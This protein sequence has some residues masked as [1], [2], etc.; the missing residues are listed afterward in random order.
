VVGKVL[1][2]HRFIVYSM[3]GS[4]ARWLR[5]MGYDTVYAKNWHDA[6]IIETA[7]KEGR[8]IVTRDHGLYV[9]AVKRGLTAI[10]VPEVLEDA[11]ALLA[12]R[13]GIPLEVDP[14]RS[15]CPLCN[16]PLRKASPEEVRGKVPPRVLE[17]YSEFWVCTGCGQVYWRG[18]HWRG[19]EK[20][21]SEARK[22]LA[23][24]QGH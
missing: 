21:L 17:R 10:L 3:L 23:E 14:D 19:I 22:R 11:L 18:G 8:I 20:T 12:L 5:M 24:L 9:R 16:A 13:F 7:E 4:L 6:R 2:K 15:R 1:R